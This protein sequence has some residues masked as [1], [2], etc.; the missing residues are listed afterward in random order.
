MEQNV[1]LSA[2]DSQTNQFLELVFI[3]RFHFVYR[4]LITDYPVPICVLCTDYVADNEDSPSVFASA[5]NV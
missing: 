5:S 3:R 2:I 4:L 1:L